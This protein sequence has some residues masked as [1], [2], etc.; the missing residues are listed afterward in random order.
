MIASHPTASLTRNRSFAVWATQ[1]F[2]ST[3]AYSIAMILI[4]SELSLDFSYLGYRFSPYN[5]DGLAALIVLTSAFAT[6]LPSAVKRFNDVALF[7]L[8]YIVFL[9]SAIIP[10][11]QGQMINAYYAFLSAGFILAS[12]ALLVFMLRR[13]TSVLTFRLNTRRWFAITIVVIQM[14][15]V[16]YFLFRFGGILNVADLSTIYEQRFAFANAFGG[17]FNAYLLAA[18]SSVFNPL[19]LSYGIYRRSIIM[20][21]AGIV[22]CAFAFTTLAQRGEII[23]ILAVPLFYF[24]MRVSAGAGFR[25]VAPILGAVTFAGYLGMDLYRADF[26]LAQE[27]YSFIFLRT[28][29]V[30][31]TAYGIYVDFFSIYPVTYFSASWPARLFIDY[32]YGQLSVGQVIGQF[33]TGVPGG[34]DQW[35]FNANFIATDGIA[36]LGL[37]G[38]P[39]AVV[40]AI[41]GLTVIS[42][43]VDGKDPAFVSAAFVPFLMSIT[44]TS[45]L[46]SMITG[47]GGLLALLIW[48]SPDWSS[49]RSG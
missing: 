10:Y 26:L 13:S 15:L 18:L 7:V 44:N 48:I 19:V 12:F 30:S 16:V 40:I 21:S 33:V 42:K 24:A 37:S 34:L 31:G 36:S 43:L 35:N 47:G 46:T 4:Y 22:G 29:L 49:E 9:P 6:L 2:V 3:L 27:L 8:Y 28:L 45:F 11:L 17:G 1:Q 23:T 25:R 14:S 32:P 41:V 38:V 5:F 39:V 20:I